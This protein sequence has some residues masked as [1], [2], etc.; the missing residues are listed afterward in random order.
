M[1]QRVF[2]R[3]Q[4]GDTTHAAEVAL[5]YMHLAAEPRQA[6][7]WANINWQQAKSFNDEQLLSKIRQLAAAES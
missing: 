1:A 6:L 2:I 5:Y 4:R 3:E 7:H